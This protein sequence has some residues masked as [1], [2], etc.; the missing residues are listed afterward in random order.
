MRRAG[1][2]AARLRCARPRGRGVKPFL[3]AAGVLVLI[4]VGAGY[5]LIPKHKELA[6]MQLKHN[7]FDKA[8]KN[9]EA[10][11]AA[12]DTSVAVVGPLADLHLHFG[13]VEKAV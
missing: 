9:F 5:L 2:R 11:L 3:I 10:Q 1:L 13:E 6:L 4:G 8:K 12:G 7:V